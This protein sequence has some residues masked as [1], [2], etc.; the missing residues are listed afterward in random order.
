[1]AELTEAEHMENEYATQETVVVYHFVTAGRD[2]PE[3]CS[4]GRDTLAVAEEFCRRPKWPYR[5]GESFVAFDDWGHG[6][7][8]AATADLKQNLG[9][10]WREF[11]QHYSITR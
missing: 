3:L 5:Q 6:T 1:M 11:R 2:H 9:R 4:V 10:T 8:V 7:C